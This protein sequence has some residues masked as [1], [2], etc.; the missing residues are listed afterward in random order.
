MGHRHVH[1]PIRVALHDAFRK[2][3][4]TLHRARFTP[5]G[6]GASAA[7]TSGYLAASFRVPIRPIAWPTRQLRRVSPWQGLISCAASK[8]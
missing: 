3:P 7:L 5:A 6:E 4:D 1:R 2:V 8:R